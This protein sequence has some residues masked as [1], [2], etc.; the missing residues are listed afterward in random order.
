MRP[1]C[2]PLPSLP[3]STLGE[4]ANAKVVLVGDHA[5]L[6]AVEAGGLFRLL[7]TETNAAS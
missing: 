5:Q 3:G 7:V 2:W 4:Q 6:G 1:A